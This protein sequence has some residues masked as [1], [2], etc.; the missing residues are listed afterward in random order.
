MIS[1]DIIIILHNTLT[2]L[3]GLEYDAGIWWNG[4]KTKRGICDED[5]VKLKHEGWRGT[6]LVLQFSL[7]LL[8][9][10]DVL[11]PPH[12]NQISISKQII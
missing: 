10:T 5:T 3:L 6:F 2:H 7:N 12:L 8:I 11:G 9:E 4:F 1:H